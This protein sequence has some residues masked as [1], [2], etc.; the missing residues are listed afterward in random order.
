MGSL[1]KDDNKF[2][3]FGGSDINTR[4]CGLV[5]Y[6]LD[7]NQVNKESDN[8]AFGFT[9]TVADALLIRIESENG[10]QYLEIKLRGGFVALELT[11][12]GVLEKREYM[13][14]SNKQFNDNR[15]Y[16][17]QYKRVRNSVSFRVDNFDKL[18]FELGGMFYDCC[19]PEL[20][21]RKMCQLGNRVN[22]FEYDAT[23]LLFFGT[24]CCAELV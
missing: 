15:Y 7:T 6:T 13:P 12:N 23:S 4:T 11:I 16:V 21:S 9:T 18:E 3:F 10:G 8:L 22:G 20:G 5:K 1:C 2:Y 14:I 17:V 24:Q 19:Q